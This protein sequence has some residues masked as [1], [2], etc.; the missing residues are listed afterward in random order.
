MRGW[1][2]SVRR[3]IVMALMIFGALVM[4][5]NKGGAIDPMQL[6]LVPLGSPVPEFD[7]PAITGRT[8]GLSSADLKGEVSLVNVFASWCAPCRQ[9]HPL[10][11]KLANQDLVPIHGLNYKDD[12]DSAR[13]WLE[14]LGNPYANI[15][16]D[17]DGRVA[18]EWGLYA[19]PQTFV[20]DETGRTAYVHTGVLDQSVIDETILP[21]IS[22]LRAEAATP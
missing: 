19:L 20:V 8:R 14:R 5:G 2:G 7:L 11:M 21:L 12:P 22:R 1:I 4:T 15:G 13:R 17:R 6:L 18:E 10:L 9:E 3:F 16:S